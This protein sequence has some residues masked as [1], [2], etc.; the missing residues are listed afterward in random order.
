MDL[1]GLA[2][3]QAK[4][5]LARDVPIRLAAALPALRTDLHVFGD[6]VFEGAFDFGSALVRSSQDS[7]KSS[8]LPL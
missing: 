2:T 7:G 5:K 6:M 3:I 1:M 4:A 8:M